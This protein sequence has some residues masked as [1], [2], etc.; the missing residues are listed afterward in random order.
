MDAHQHHAVAR[1]Q[2]MDVEAHA[3]ARPQARR[4]DLLGADKIG[5]LGDLEV[6]LRARD[7]RH[8]EAGG[9][10]ERAVVGHALAREGA[11][12]VQDRAVAKALRRLRPLEAGPVDRAGDRAV[13][14]PA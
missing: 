12:R 5:G 14:R 7:H 13:A 2:A 3:G 1:A 6:A 4:E 8:R 10:G 9:L 11:M